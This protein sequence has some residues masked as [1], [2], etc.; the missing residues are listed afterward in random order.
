MHTVAVKME[1]GGKAAKGGIAGGGHHHSP[2]VGEVGGGKR[3]AMAVSSAL[4]KHRH[5]E[6]RRGVPMGSKVIASALEHSGG[7]P[8]HSHRGVEGEVVESDGDRAGGEGPAAVVPHRHNDR[9]AINVKAER[10]CA[11]ELRCQLLGRRGGGAES[12]EEVPGE[13]LG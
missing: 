8:S 13:P 4:M 5:C 2:D 6:I 3:R 10:C 1:G 7:E 12:D 9:H 11:G